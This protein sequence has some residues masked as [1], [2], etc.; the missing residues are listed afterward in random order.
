MKS[1]VA[2]PKSTRNENVGYSNPG[3]PAALGGQ[4]YVFQIWR[5]DVPDESKVQ[6]PPNLKTV[7]PTPAGRLPEIHRIDVHHEFDVRG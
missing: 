2:N 6:R 4:V 7:S 5:D 3:H 1:R